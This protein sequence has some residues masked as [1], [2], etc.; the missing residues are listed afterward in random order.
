MYYLE[1]FCKSLLFFKIFT[2]RKYNTK[3]VCLY[4]LIIYT[5]RIEDKVFLYRQSV[6][7]FLPKL[8]DQPKNH[9]LAELTTQCQRNGPCNITQTSAKESKQHFY[10]RF[11][12]FFLFLQSDL[13]FLNF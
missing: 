1:I 5:F 10:K 4:F 3:K 13:A 6:F 11:V 12:L 9:M 7:N 8:L 2:I